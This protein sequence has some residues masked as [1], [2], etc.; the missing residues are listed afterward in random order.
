MNREGE[1]KHI[2]F[3]QN[4][5]PGAT[6]DP[7]GTT[8]S[9]SATRNPSSGSKSAVSTSFSLTST[10]PSP[11]E[12]FLSRTTFLRKQFSP[13]PGTANGTFEAAEE[14]LGAELEL[15]EEE[16]EAPPPLAALSLAS[17]LTLAS[18][19]SPTKSLPTKTTFSSLLPDPTWLLFPTQQSVSSHPRRTHPSPT[20]VRVSDEALPMREGGATPRG[21]AG[22][23]T[24]ALPPPW[25]ATGGLGEARARETST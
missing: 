1:E 19:G 20:R 24:N 9:P 7:R 5:V 17:A 6:T 25:R 4:S 3:F 14:G 8:I 18:A 10:Q 12:A 21:G 22:G 13:T 23:A 16:L 2:F 15:E 11:T